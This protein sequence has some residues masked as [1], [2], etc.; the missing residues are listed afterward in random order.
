MRGKWLLFSGSVI[1]LAIAAG[2]LSVLKKPPEAQKKAPP[3]AQPVAS[4][5]VTFMGKLQAAHVVSI[6]SPVDGVI[7]KW[8]VETGQEVLEGQPLG[9]VLSTA[10]ES[11]REQAQNELEQAQTK[12]SNIEGQILAAR[13]E[14]ARADSDA[15]RAKTELDKFEKAFQ[16]QE[17]LYKEGATP[18]LVKE[19]AEREY[20]AALEESNTAAEIAK[21]MTERVSKL[22]NDLRLAKVTL[23]DRTG[24]VNAAKNDLES[25]N[26]LS[27]AD[28]T[29]IKLAVEAGGEVDSSIRDLIQIAVDPALLQLVVEPDARTLARIKPGMPALVIVPDVSSEG[30]PGAVK[31]LKGTQVIIEFT[32]PNP[33]IKHGM[34]GSARIKLT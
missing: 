32:S 14:A 31:D 20:K 33:A 25:T 4:E 16:R 26:I 12:V 2:A 7:D 5:E 17:F 15:S 28:G 24:A 11:S 9:H 18:R 22:E 29:V 30:L 1:L 10:L 6:P 13:L 27:P 8:D 34:T 19:K 21:Q 3:V 23:E